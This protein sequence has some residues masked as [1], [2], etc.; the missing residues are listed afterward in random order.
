MV[1][2]Q[3]IENLLDFKGNQ[4]KWLEIAEFRG[5]HYKIVP[6]VVTPG[7]QNVN[8]LIKKKDGIRDF[9]PEKVVNTE[10]VYIG[11]MS[12]MILLLKVACCMCWR[13]S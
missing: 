7:P 12:Y 13:A 8:I 10:S 6:G 1:L 5:Q 4:E 2:A 3:N 9:S 11:H